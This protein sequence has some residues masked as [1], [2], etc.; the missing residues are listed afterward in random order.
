M[1]DTEKFILIN[2]DPF[3]DFIN[4]EIKRGGAPSDLLENFADLAAW[5][6]AAGIID[7]NRAESFLDET[8]APEIFAEALDLRKN[9]RE[10]ASAMTGGREIKEENIRAVNEKL[11]LQKSHPQIAIDKGL[12][13]KRRSGEPESMR[14]I[15][16]L[17][18]ESAAD[19]LAENRPELLKVCESEDCVLYFYDTTKNHSRR[20]CSMA[21]CGN[22]AKANAFYRRKKN[23]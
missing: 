1:L 6:V 11:K 4:T 18:A 17:I 16:V 12:Y 19:L 15:L 14:Q 7:R 20:W 21:A 22:R 5:A 9:L 3:L 13:V 23:K 10:M 2:D 8:D